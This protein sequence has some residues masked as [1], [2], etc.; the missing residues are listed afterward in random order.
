[1]PLPIHVSPAI[2]TYRIGQRGSIEVQIV[3]IAA[4]PSSA[5]V[6]AMV[7]SK[8][9]A[10][11]AVRKLQSFLVERGPH[12]Q[13]I[14]ITPDGE[15]DGS[16]PL[17]VDAGE[18]IQVSVELRS[19][20]RLVG[21]FQARLSVTGA[22][23][24][25][26]QN[27]FVAV[28]I[29]VLA[30]R[31]EYVGPA[32]Y[33]YIDENNRG[34]FPVSGRVNAIAFDPLR[35]D[36]CYLGAP[37]GGLWRTI[38]MGKTW[39]PLSNTWPA[40]PVSSIAVDPTFG[41]TIFVGTGDVP[42]NVTG[43]L[44][45]MRTINGGG[46]WER[47]GTSEFGESAVSSVVVN[48]ASPS[49]LYAAEFPGRVWL[50]GDSGD[51][52]SVAADLPWTWWMKLDRAVPS[53]SAP[54]RFYAI[55]EGEGAELWRTDGGTV[56]TKLRTPFSVDPTTGKQRY[57]QRP[58][59]AC[60]MFDSD[61]VYLMSHT[62]GQIWA[63]SNAGMSWRD[64]TGGYPDGRSDGSNLYRFC[65]ACA[66]DGDPVQGTARD[67][68]YAGVY[69]I[70]RS[71]PADGSWEFVLGDSP[72]H[73]DQHAI[74]VDPQDP[75]RVAVGND[76][77]IYLVVGKSVQSANDTLAVTQIYRADIVPSDPPA[78]L[79]GTQD[80]GTAALL[81][82]GAW[83]MAGG[84][85]GGSCLINPD[86]TNIQYLT[87]NFDDANQCQLMRTGNRW[88]T[89]KDIIA[90]SMKTESRSLTPA[91]TLDPGNPSKL[92]L[93]TN[94]LYRWDEQGS[95]Q[96]GWTPHIG[97][98]QLSSHGYLN[99]IAVAPNDSQRIYTGSSDGELWMSKNSG[100]SWERIDTGLPAML[101]LGIQAI[102][103]SP[104]DPAQIVVGLWEVIGQGRLWLCRDTS[105]LQRT[106]MDISSRGSIDGL[107]DTP[108]T[109]IARDISE[110]DSVWYVGGGQ[111]VYWTQ[112]GGIA[113]LDATASLGLPVLGVS[114][115]K[116]TGENS[117]LYAATFGRGMWKI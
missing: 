48:N 13:I 69:S 50:S 18:M 58:L 60:S 113:W 71:A 26:T 54:N 34:Q 65:F 6:T 115:M 41:D 63:S 38:D 102:S 12:G 97:G 10:V 70:Y 109:C 1:M 25:E 74:A 16:T 61:A 43:G 49:N 68:L 21:R 32:N 7:E 37:S 29:S 15:T 44:G 106:W 19:P 40:Q 105:A 27:W 2:L 90:P 107:P 85:D 112:D 5:N 62:D 100:D 56:W 64:I 110:P 22:A 46:G 79:C 75:S 36:I 111:G 116:A 57:Q 24:S 78:I 55:G 103:I 81:A 95:G 77:G 47:V 88:Q 94:Y 4:A 45:V 117:V 42:G 83:A 104:N 35:R 8:G 20:N 30:P 98:S 31:W 99:V 76:G 72:G 53:A 59:V 80:V 23:D 17:S 93:G 84:G 28:P 86:D 9:P 114:A 89:S 51:H 52:W 82:S 66:Y 3:T 11:L 73:A 33:A 14:D 87:A 91:L 101:G 108:V 92:Y 39:A 96:G 67:V